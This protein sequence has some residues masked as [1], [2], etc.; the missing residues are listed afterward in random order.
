M[1]DLNLPDDLVRFLKAGKQLE[2]DPQSCEAGAVTLVPFDQLKIELFPMDCQSTEVAN[3]DPH[4]GELGCYLVEA[5]NLTAACSDGYDGVGLLLWLPRDNRYATWDSSHD[6]I[7]VFGPKVKWSD[8][9][10][11]PAQHINAQW[12]GAFED[13]VRSSSLS[14]WLHH[15]YNAEQVHHPLPN[16]DEWYEA[17]WTR[18][19]LFRSGKQVRYP[20]EV[21]IRF[22]RAGNQCTINAQTKKGN[23]DKWKALAP[24]TLTSRDW[25]QLQR[26]LETGFWRRLREKAPDRESE[27]ET[28]WSFSGFRDGTFAKIFRSFDA[29][30]SEGD[31]LHELGKRLAEL[32]GSDVFKAKRGSK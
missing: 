31:P 25:K 28:Y 22:E 3:K 16:L 4:K 14:P 32:A 10:T 20:Q 21:K 23:T 8:I 18:R 15:R 30:S 24:R 29:R 6:Y 1:A 26:S 2:Y 5:V 13:S 17:E 7:G 9:V 12:E 27:T 19:G 11:A